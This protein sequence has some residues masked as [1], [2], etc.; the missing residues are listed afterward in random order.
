MAFKADAVAEPVR[1]ELEA[2]PVAT[3]GDN[4]A[5][6]RVHTGRSHAGARGFERS[7]L[8]AQH[9]IE[10]ALHFVGGFAEHEGTSDVGSV[11]FD[12]AA[13][14]EHEDGTLAQRLRLA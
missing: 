5:R 13:I 14:V 9:Q 4:F 1:E 11:A 10:D 8:R 3:I 7:G 12:E 6:S 2:W